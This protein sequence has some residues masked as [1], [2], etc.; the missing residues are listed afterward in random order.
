MSEPAGRHGQRVRRKADVAEDLGAL[1]I[2]ALTDPLQHILG[3]ALPHVPG[4][5]QAPGGA[6][7]SVRDTVKGGEHVLAEVGRNQ[8]PGGAGGCVT[9]ELEV[10]HRQRNHPQR[11]G[12]A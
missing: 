1:A 3:E 2:Q 9:E 6:A 5:D 7:S 8:G 4:G 10:P 11:G 12:V